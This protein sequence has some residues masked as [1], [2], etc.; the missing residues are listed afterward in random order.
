MKTK[1][2]KRFLA[3]LMAMMFAFAMMVP[4]MAVGDEV[5]TNSALEVGSVTDTIMPLAAGEADGIW[6]E[7]ATGTGKITIQFASDNENLSIEGMN[8]EAHR[9]L[10]SFYDK[11]YPAA[12]EYVPVAAFNDFFSNITLA[13]YKNLAE[14]GLDFYITYNENRELVL[15]HYDAATPPSGKYIVIEDF[16]IASKYLDLDDLA[17]IVAAHPD[18]NFLAAYLMDAILKNNDNEDN[19]TISE[20]AR[21]YAYNE[22]GHDPDLNEGVNYKKVVAD[23]TGVVEFTELAFGYWVLLSTKAPA[24]VANVQTIMKLTPDADNEAVEF[25][26]EELELD[27]QVKNITR[28]DADYAKGTSARIGD[29]LEYKIAFTLQSLK[30]YV[31]SGYTFKLS[32]EMNNLK[33]DPDF[34]IKVTFETSADKKNEYSSEDDFDDV[35]VFT[36]DYDEGTQTQTFTLNFDKDR[37]KAIE[38]IA[39]NETT[40]TV[41]YR[42]QLMSGA[43]LK[44]TN[45]AV[46]KHSNDPALPNDTVELKGS[47]TVYSYGLDID[48]VFSDN[49][50]D[51]SEVTFTLT[52][53]LTKEKLTFIKTGNVYRVCDYDELENS[54]LDDAR[55]TDLKLTNEGKLKI[56]G[57]SE[58]T[59]ILKETSTDHGYKKAGRIAVKIKGVNFDLDGGSKLHCSVTWDSQ[60]L[61]C[62]IDTLQ[63]ETGS[64]WKD[65]DSQ[66]LCFD[67]LNVKGIDLP[68]TGAMGVWLFGICGMILI[69]VTRYMRHSR[70]KNNAA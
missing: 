3:M 30:D 63:G 7:D 47:A 25:K 32:D 68:S 40:V 20:W 70:R 46:W 12:P 42:A 41:V 59:Y 45:N 44:N 13:N 58:G 52:D 10:E 50:G 35:L 24:G 27:K 65:A 23:S 33:L 6:D 9:M 21:D 66:W 26:L 53:Y 55:T 51:F 62:D 15:N 29:T 60:S 14:D 16:D 1:K 56:Y 69:V 4:V 37:L 54:D 43:E 5:T 2:T 38:H 34:D 57:L 28:E 49:N 64:E 17:K 48:K 61:D 19:K 11:A 36:E 31:K 18:N 39:D 8:I 67:V 22:I